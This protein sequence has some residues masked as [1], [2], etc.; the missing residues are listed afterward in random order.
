MDEIKDKKLNEERLDTVNG[1]GSSYISF[2]WLHYYIGKELKL[3][4][5]SKSSDPCKV[6]LESVEYGTGNCTVRSVSKND[7]DVIYN[8][9]YDFSVVS[10]TDDGNTI[11]AVIHYHVSS[12]KVWLE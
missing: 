3:S 6:I 4:H 8:H 5:G 2:K 10:Y 1:G 12:T 9:L 7:R 11:T